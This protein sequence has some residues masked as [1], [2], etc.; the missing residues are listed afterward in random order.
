MNTL[1]VSQLLKLRELI[2]A[3]SVKDVLDGIAELCREKSSRVQSAALQ[4]ELRQVSGLLLRTAEDK[5]IRYLP[6]VI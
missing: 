3:T 4:S 1:T 5:V 6:N 2:S